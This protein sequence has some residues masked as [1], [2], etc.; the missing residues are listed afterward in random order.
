MTNARA[1]DGA[2][3]ERAARIEA[4]PAEPEQS[5]T[6]QR[7]RHVVRQQ[8]RAWIIAALADDDRR[9]ERGNAGVHVDDRAA[10]EIE[11]A[12]VGEPAAAPHPVRHRRV[13]EERPQDDENE[14][15]REA[16]P[17]DDRAGDERGRDDAER[18]LIGHEQVMRDGALRLEP[19]ASQEQP[20]EIAD[21]VIPGRKR[22]RIP[23]DRP[24]DADESERDKAHHHRVQGV[25]RSHEAAVE[26][27]ERRRHQQDQCGRDQHPRSVCLI[28]HTPLRKK[29]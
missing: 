27:C 1:G 23:D 11:R 4:E 12:H 26:K 25:L 29:E 8:R 6:E 2:C 18:A 13:D 5:C 17:L 9:D 24:E 22:Q 19:D 10:C 21:V 20:R 16:H 3:R 28:H 7:E 14:I 15:R